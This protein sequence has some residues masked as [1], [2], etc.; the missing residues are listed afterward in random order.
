MWNAPIELGRPA[1]ATAPFQPG[2][3]ITRLAVHPTA[4]LALIAFD[5]LSGLFDP[6][7]GIG[8]CSE[9]GQEVAAFGYP[10][11]SG[12]S[13]VEPIP[14]FFRGNILRT[15]PHSRSPFSYAAA[16]LSFGA[17]GGLSGG[18]VAHRDDPGRVIGVVTENFRSST[19]LEAFSE[20]SEGGVVRVVE[21]HSVIHYGIAVLLEHVADWID[22]EIANTA[23]SA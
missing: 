22:Q 1:E 10:E 16:E 3:P 9:A 23:E 6:F 13:G 4:D 8:S 14:R 11:H 7:V 17:P 21:Q 12:E 2:I 20:T 19:L 15:F 18:P 5:D